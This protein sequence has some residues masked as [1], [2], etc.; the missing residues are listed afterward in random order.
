MD[1]QLILTL[2]KQR[3]GITSTVRDA[4]LLAIIESSLSNLENLRGVSLR[5]DR[6]DHM[7]FI[8]AYTVWVYQSK[9]SSGDMP[10]HLRYDLNNLIL[11][12]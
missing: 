3:L 7:F 4:Y 8:V 5:L 9:D 11:S 12:K 6:P 2:I 10:K 1:K